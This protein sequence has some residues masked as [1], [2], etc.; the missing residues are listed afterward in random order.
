MKDI[1]TTIIGTIIGAIVGAATVEVVRKLIGKQ[2]KPDWWIYIV[3]AI[4]VAA[5]F[6]FVSYKIFGDKPPTSSSPHTTITA[7]I[8]AK[9]TYP[10]EGDS[11]DPVVDV[12]VKCKNIDMSNHDLWVIV[13][14]DGV[15]KYYP[16]SGR[17]IMFDAEGKGV[18]K[19]YLGEPPD[20]GKKFEILIAL[21][22]KSISDVFYKYNDKG[23][24][25]GDWPGVNIS[26]V[27][28]INIMDR[29]TVVRK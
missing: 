1:I 18:G 11:V 6:G 13:M 16:Q 24:E 7:I 10:S 22:D 27:P 20:H 25:T 3:C 19:A 26:E 2:I 8:T 28:N 12:R 17:P 5:I 4:I 29:V 15:S 23:N 21:V 14:I 9:I